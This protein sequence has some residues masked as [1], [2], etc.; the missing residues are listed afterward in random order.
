MFVAV[1]F[2][3]RLKCFR[4]NILVCKKSNIWRK[5]YSTG[6][7]KAA[8][9][10]LLTSLVE[11]TLKI[12]PIERCLLEKECFDLKGI[13]WLWSVT[14]QKSKKELCYNGRRWSGRLN[15]TRQPIRWLASF[16][17]SSS[18]SQSSPLSSSS[19][20]S[21]SSSSSFDLSVLIWPGSPLD[22]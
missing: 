17:P 13:V 22:G 19:I 4:P 7:R 21:S 1:A 20:S 14:R 2:V 8:N 3:A 12:F 15:L 6:R 16:S 18:F 10:T 5:K 9:V 11:G